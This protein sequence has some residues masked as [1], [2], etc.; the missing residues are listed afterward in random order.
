MSMYCKSLLVSI[1]LFVK[2]SLLR[3][4]LKMLS[5]SETVI[6][7]KNFCLAHYFGLDKKQRK[8]ALHTHLNLTATGPFQ[9]I[10]E[11]KGL[12]DQIV[13]SFSGN[14]SLRW[15]RLSNCDWSVT[16]WIIFKNGLEKSI[17]ST[18]GNGE[19]YLDY[20]CD[21]N[22]LTGRVINVTISIDL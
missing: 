12:V 13:D 21:Q 22:P 15:L 5:N 19:Y 7:W 6:P 10:D 9:E 4:I 2:P 18:V 11:M 1:V 20:Y 8:L 14:A 3:I 16:Q 17:L